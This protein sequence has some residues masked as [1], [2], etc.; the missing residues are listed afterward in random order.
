M[1]CGAAVLAHHFLKQAQVLGYEAGS[2]SDIPMTPVGGIGRHLADC[3]GLPLTLEGLY[4]ADGLIRFFF[5]DLFFLKCLLKVV[6][7]VIILC[8]LRR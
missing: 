6:L 5:F 2:K 8:S 3:R 4:Y 7:V 1:E